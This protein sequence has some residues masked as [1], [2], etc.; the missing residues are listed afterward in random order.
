MRPIAFLWGFLPIFV[1][2]Q[3]VQHEKT[4]VMAYRFRCHE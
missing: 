2:N 1:A 4:N 3:F